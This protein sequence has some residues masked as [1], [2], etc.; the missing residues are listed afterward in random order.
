MAKLLDENEAAGLRVSVKDDVLTRDVEAWMRAIRD[1]RP[2]DGQTS[3]FED[4]AIT[5]RG[6]LKAG[7]VVEPALSVGEVADLPPA[8]TRFYGQALERFYAEVTTVPLA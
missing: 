3:R 5:L 4:M 7:V 2:K 8:H 6:A 1:Q